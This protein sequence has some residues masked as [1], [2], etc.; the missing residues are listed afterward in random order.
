MRVPLCSGL[1]LALASAAPAQCLFTSV[2]AQPVGPN[3]NVSYTGICAIAPSPSFLR[4]DLDQANCE[5]E[6]TVT[7][8]EGCG[9]SVPFRVLAI[10]FQP[11]FVPLPEFGA[12]CALQLVPVGIATTTS[13]SVTL[14]LPPNLPQLS[15]LAQGAAWSSFPFAPVPDVLVFTAPYAISLQ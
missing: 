7:A 6:V 2:T 10:G 15:F 5:L 8:F 9:T 14:S 3:C 1:V 11:A 13:P 12:G 4:T